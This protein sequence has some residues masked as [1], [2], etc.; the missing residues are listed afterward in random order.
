MAADASFEEL[1]R[2]WRRLAAGDRK[3]VLRHMPAER[4]R[5]LQRMLA[6]GGDQ[7]EQAAPYRAYSPWLGELIE[8]CVNGETGVAAPKPH[9]T[10]ALTQ[11][12][13]QVEEELGGKA[14]SR[15]VFDLM[16]SAVHE[17]RAK[18]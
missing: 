17:W 14:E 18:L 8:D 12:H 9:T 3:A 1:L 7:A 6:E 4:R 13:R 15:S 5:T 10:A 2:E 16:R 11:A